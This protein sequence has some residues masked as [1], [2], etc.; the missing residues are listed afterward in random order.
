L[1]QKNNGLSTFLKQPKTQGLEKYF[2]SYEMSK[3][4]EHIFIHL[5][6]KEGLRA[7]VMAGT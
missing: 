4:T 3:T 6:E 1:G 2:T 5:Q 7:G